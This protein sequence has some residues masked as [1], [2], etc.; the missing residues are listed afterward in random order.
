M[1]SF[2]LTALGGLALVLVWKTLIWAV[3]L[4]RRDASIVD[5]FWGPGFMLLTG[6][7]AFTS[8]P[9]HPR[10]SLLPALVA[11]WGLRLAVHIVLRS[12]GQE[13]DP[14]YQAMRRRAGG[15]FWWRSLFMVFYLQGVI[16]WLVALPIIHAQLA[17]YPARLTVLDGLGIAIFTAGLFFEAVGDWQLTRFRSRPENRGQ[18]LDTGLWRYTRHPNYFGDALVWWGLFLMG[19][20][21]SGGWMFVFGPLLMN[22]LLLKVS[23]VTLLEDRLVETRP[24]YRSYVARTSAFV[25]WPPRVGT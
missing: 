25:P 21:T 10:Q 17:P 20:A 6:W 22:L 18:V 9:S 12:R 11:I 7:V 3:S 8:P 5:I 15:S 24:A 4:V 2:W 19:A 13:E 16:L 14:R 23:G 1:S